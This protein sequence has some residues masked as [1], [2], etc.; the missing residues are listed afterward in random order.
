[1]S[2]ITLRSTITLNDGIQMPLFGLGMFQM[3]LGQSSVNAV[4]CALQNGYRLID[5]AAFYKYLF[6]LYSCDLFVFFMKIKAMI[7]L[8][9]F[10]FCNT[11]LVVVGVI[12]QRK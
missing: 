5:T 7:I 8:Q 3:T 1:M 12:Q 9:W 2:K 6:F 4:R 11:T 10:C